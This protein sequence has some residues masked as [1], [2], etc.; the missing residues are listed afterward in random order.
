[1]EIATKVIKGSDLFTWEGTGLSID[2]TDADETYIIWRDHG[3]PVGSVVACT[4]FM[5][6]ANLTDF[7]GG[8]QVFPLFKPDGEDYIRSGHE[9]AATPNTTI[10]GNGVWYLPIPGNDAD[11]STYYGGDTH[12]PCMPWGVSCRLYCNTAGTFDV[13]NQ[14]V[15]WYMKRS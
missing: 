14:L 1:M 5:N 3:I 7:E 12:V 11:V 15:V 9:L 10:D 2:A 4:W 6:I 13:E 8:Q